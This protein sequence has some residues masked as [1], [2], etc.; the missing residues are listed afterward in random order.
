MHHANIWNSVKEEKMQQ[1]NRSSIKWCMGVI[2]R[3]VQNYIMLALAAA[4]LSW[5]Q[6]H[7]QPCLTLLKRGF[8]FS[9]FFPACTYSKKVDLVWFRSRIV[10]NKPQSLLLCLVLLWQEFPILILGGQSNLVSMLYVNFYT[11]SQLQL[12]WSLKQ[13]SYSR[14]FMKQKFYI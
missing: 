11:C 2:F 5:W 4:R 1:C 12:L 13:A 14:T 7:F 9:F 8:S 6:G 10:H 3:H